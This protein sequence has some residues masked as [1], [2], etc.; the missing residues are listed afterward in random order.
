MTDSR[1]DEFLERVGRLL[2]SQKVGV[3]ATH[4]EDSP[5]QSLI[6]FQSSEDLREI[7]FCTPKYTRK[8][9][10]LEEDPRVALLIDD[11]RNEAKDFDAC[12]A[13]TVKGTVEKMSE[14]Q[15]RHVVPRYLNRHPYLEEFVAS[16]S[17]LFYRIRVQ[18]YS[19]VSSFQ[20]VEE[21]FLQ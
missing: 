3:L 13:V 15:K 8:V 2:S 17:C 12:V 16:P 21:L 9:S 19:L 11:R 6:A 14:D 18:S 7:F 20:R 4:Y 5:H 1:R 10:A